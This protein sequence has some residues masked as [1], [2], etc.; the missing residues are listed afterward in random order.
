[1]KRKRCVNGKGDEFHFK[2]TFSKDNLVYKT[3]YLDGKTEG[4]KKQNIQQ[5]LKDF[6][7]PFWVLNNTI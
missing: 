1:M 6:S 2:E 7:L 3:S 4:Y 5:K